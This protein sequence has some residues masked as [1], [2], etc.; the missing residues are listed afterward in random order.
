MQYILIAPPKKSSGTVLLLSVREEPV[1]R[2]DV[3]ITA[4]WKLKLV[5]DP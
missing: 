1:Y 4:I 5:S 3:K 2:T